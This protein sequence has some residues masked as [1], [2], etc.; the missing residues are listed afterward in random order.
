MQRSLDRF[1]TVPVCTARHSSR[2]HHYYYDSTRLRRG[3]TGTFV[4]VAQYFMPVFHLSTTWFD[5]RA[6]F[7]SLSA[8]LPIK[9]KN[10]PKNLLK[11]HLKMCLLFPWLEKPKK[12]SKNLQFLSFHFVKVQPNI[13]PSPCMNGCW[14]TLIRQEHS[15]EILTPNSFSS[16]L[17]SWVHCS[18]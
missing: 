7:L 4:A 5:S 3:V 12:Q 9:D 6:A 17:I 14:Q 2:L 18:L 10:A 13:K 11:T 1:P 15:S 8:V 16:L